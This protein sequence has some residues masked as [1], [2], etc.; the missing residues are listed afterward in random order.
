MGSRPRGSRSC[1]Q[2]SHGNGVRGEKRTEEE[3]DEGKKEPKKRGRERGAG[4][5]VSGSRWMVGRSAERA[6]MDRSRPQK[7]DKKGQQ[8]QGQKGSHKTARPRASLGAF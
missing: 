8:E 6:W 4:S 2:F 1:R 7:G 5:S 3:K